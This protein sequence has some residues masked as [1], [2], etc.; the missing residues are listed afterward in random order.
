MSHNPDI[1]ALNELGTRILDCAFEVHREL[2]P[3]LL[4]CLYEEALAHEFTLQG[5]PCEQ[6]KPVPV[7]YKGHTL[8]RPLTLDL[9]VDDQ[10]I[11]EAKAVEKHN[12]LFEA[13]LLTY[14]R[15]NSLHLGYVLNFGQ[16]RMKE[17]I[18]RVINT[19]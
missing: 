7:V 13:Q 5:I 10:I 6:Q 15:L 17:G 16:A 18:H 3:G 11:I 2:G 4:E 14:L 9:I 19:R 8:S 12:P 1:K